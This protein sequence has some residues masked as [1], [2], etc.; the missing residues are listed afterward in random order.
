MKKLLICICSILLGASVYGQQELMVSQYMFN[1]LLL[2]PAYSGSHPYF[3][4]S[5]LHRSQWVDFDKSPTSQ[6]FSIDGPVANDKIGIGFLVT[7]DQLGIIQ[8]LDVSANGS[9]RMQLGSGTL[10][11]GLKVGMASYSADLSEVTIWDEN[12]PVYQFN[13]IKGEFVTKFG[14]GAYYH[15]D[16]WFAGVSVPLTAAIDDNII[17]D[18]PG[19]DRYF[20]SHIYVNGGVV[21][22]PS[23]TLAIK[24]SVLI[25]YVS[26]APIQADIN[27]NVLLY[28]KL[29]LG[30][31]YRSGDALIGMVEFN[32]TPQLRAGYAYDFTLTD[33]G[34][35]SNGSHEVMLAFDFGKDI[36][37][38]KKS[39]RY[40]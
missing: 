2:N 17:S 13:D 26:G 18:V 8:Q 28:R 1:G 22:E 10:A 30:M 21:I 20:T 19:A 32:F 35:Y 7:N 15:T 6:V 3:S 31:G 39:P 23:Y 29:W 12:D 5:L 40:F 34:D 14:F 37:S 25:K 16:K 33:I 24:P 11:L 36:D 27:C 4:A 38:K 9:Y